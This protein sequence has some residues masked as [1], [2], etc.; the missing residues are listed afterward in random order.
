[1]A[2]LLIKIG[3]GANYDD[4][5]CLCAFNRRRIRCVHAEHLCHLDHAGFNRDGLR[6]A[7]S[8]P[9]SLRHHTYEYLFRRVSEK[10]IERHN[11][12]DGT[13]DTFGPESI[14]VDQYLRRRLKH[15]RHAVFGSRGREYWYGGR[16][17]TSHAKL[18]AVWNAIATDAG[19][20]E[21]EEEFTLWPMGRL[22][23]R[24]HLA[25][26]VQDFDDAEAEGLMSP[27]IE[28]DNDGN[29]VKDENGTPRVISKRNINVD[30]RRDLLPDLG[31]TEADVLD[32]EKPIG[33]DIVIA[34]GKLRHTSKDQPLQSDRAKLQS[35]ETGQR[36]SNEV[37]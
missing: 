12:L 28:R 15:K 30:W 2:E 11:L 21:A 14:A 10:T 26:R 24:H 4:G 29:P 18:D 23:I 36:L 34:S 5:D 22:D 37:R 20:L 3:P 19:R 35:K 25:V 27:R 32:R 31:V 13:V 1:L 33:R 6:P 17:D 7:G 9:Q 8:L 16:I